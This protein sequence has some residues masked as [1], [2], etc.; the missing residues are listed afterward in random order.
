MTAR[1]LTSRMGC[2]LATWVDTLAV[3]LAWAGPSATLALAFALHGLATYLS[4]WVPD[5]ARVARRSEVKRQL[6]RVMTLCVPVVGPMLAWATRNHHS[7]TRRREREKLASFHAQFLEQDEPRPERSPFTGDFEHDIEVLTDAESYNAIL[8]FGTADHKRSALRRLAD[9]GEP[10]HIR[11]LRQCLGAQDPEIRLFAY[12]QLEGIEQELCTVL[13]AARMDAE[14]NPGDQASRAAYADAHAALASCGALDEAM[15]AWHDQEAGRIRGELS[16]G[17][18]DGTEAESPEG[19]E[20]PAAVLRT[21]AE[22]AFA[23]RD[24]NTVR[25]LATELLQRGE[26]LPAWLDYVAHGKQEGAA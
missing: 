4:G 5:S 3:V 23:A 20:L 9:L 13:D 1:A 14:D 18:V 21:Q 6:A 12:G 19:G 7:G 24:F 26:E 25:A 8:E 10:Q 2:A 22:E 11:L 15:S 16:D 17:A